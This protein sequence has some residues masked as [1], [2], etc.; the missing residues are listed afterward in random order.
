MARIQTP[1]TVLRLTVLTLLVALSGVGCASKADSG[2]LMIEKDLIDEIPVSGGTYRVLV[3]SG[4][5]WTASTSDSW[6]RTEKSDKGVTRTIVT[7]VVEPNMTTNERSGQLT[8]T[9]E[10]GGRILLIEG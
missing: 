7:I 9:T 10:A 8:F 2:E 3:R 1:L 6:F 4:D 5:V